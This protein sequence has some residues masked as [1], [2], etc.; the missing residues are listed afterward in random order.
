MKK[1]IT[2]ILFLVLLSSCG[3]AYVNTP[4]ATASP[5]ITPSV[6][7]YITPAVT[8][9]IAQPVIAA[10]MQIETLT[11]SNAGCEYPCFWGITPGVTT[12]EEA[13]AII[14]PLTFTPAP[15]LDEH[16]S[17]V[18]D[19]YFYDTQGGL[20]AGFEDLQLVISEG[21]IQTVR[22]DPGTLAIWEVLTGLGQ[23]QEVLYRFSALDYPLF[24]PR[25]DLIL[26]YPARGMAAHLV[27]SSGFEVVDEESKTFQLPV[28]MMI[29]ETTEYFFFP[30]GYEFPQTEFIDTLLSGGSSYENIR[31]ELGMTPEEFTHSFG[32]FQL[33]DGLELTQSE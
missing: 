14:E 26:L 27:F 21:V 31:D 4:T 23:P 33:D 13:V 24:S 16:G 19:V 9:D 8:P 30:A 22:Y 2:T 6:T 20:A 12:L 28:G 17:G 25:L 1:T 5:S 18:W 11:A 15:T 7:A 10:M 29:S 32:D 3:P